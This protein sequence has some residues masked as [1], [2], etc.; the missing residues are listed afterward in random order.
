MSPHAPFSRATRERG[1]SLIVVLLI[2]IVVSV[3]G[4]GSAQLSI[5]AERG[6]R[7]D[8]DMQVA[9]LAAEEAL[10]DAEYDIYGPNTSTHER[11]KLFDPFNNS[12]F[13][14][15]CGTS[16]EPNEGL[17]AL[18]ESSTPAW[19]TVDFTATGSNARTT[20]FGSHTGRGMATG[21]A[22]IQPAK[23]PRYVIEPI[24]DFGNRDLSR[25]R[26][27]YRVTAMG[28]GPREDIQAVSQIL[29]RKYE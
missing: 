20:E 6:A 29:Y 2:L 7:N 15:D 4:V 8:R 28:F 25:Q 5:M 21:S 19:L 10:A 3:L 14:T 1:V 22:G 17:C 16:S 27:I 23:L 11:L 18:V 26:Y 24:P 13:A 12:A 9:S